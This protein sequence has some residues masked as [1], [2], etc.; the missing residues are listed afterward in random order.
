MNERMNEHCIKVDKLSD[1]EISVWAFLLECM[2]EYVFQRYSDEP[3]L[4]D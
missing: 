1:F 4:S 2:H 3:M